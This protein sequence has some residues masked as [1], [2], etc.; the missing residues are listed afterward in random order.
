MVSRTFSQNPCTRVKLATTANKEV[1]SLSKL[2]GRTRLGGD[3]VVVLGAGSDGLMHCTE[4]SVPAI[5]QSSKIHTRRAAERQP[6][7]GWSTERH[8]R[9]D[10][11]K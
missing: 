8:P 1:S 10:W 3:I 4:I 9:S 5:S 11:S 2:L 6:V 7:S